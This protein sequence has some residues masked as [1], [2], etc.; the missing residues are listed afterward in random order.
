LAF[1]GIA[2]FARQWILISRRQV[3][4][5]GSGCHRLWV[6][7]GGSA[8]QSG[9]WAVDVEEGTLDEN[10]Q[11]RKWDVSARTGEAEAAEQ[12]AGGRKKG[13]G[14]DTE[15]R[16][17]VLEVLKAQPQGETKRGLAKRTRLGKRMVDRVVDQLGQEGAVIPT[18]IRKTAGRG[19]A[20]HDAWKLPGP[21]EQDGEVA[22]AQDG[23]ASEGEPPPDDATN[24][25]IADG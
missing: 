9:L 6:S 8:G 20:P 3:Y 24:P 17:K 18:S 14:T 2:E 21:D 11:G 25:G 1:A 16:A 10:F 13:R 4:T 22:D 19:D 15:A 12:K 5:V 23:R 7:V